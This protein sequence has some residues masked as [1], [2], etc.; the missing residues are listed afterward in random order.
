MMLLLGALDIPRGDEGGVGERGEEGGVGERE[1]DNMC[2]GN[3][4]AE[5]SERESERDR[6]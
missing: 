1:G 5:E 3:G 6:E 4:G 2:M